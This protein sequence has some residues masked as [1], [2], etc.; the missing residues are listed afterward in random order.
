[1]EGPK[2]GW[3]SPLLG[4]RSFLTAATELHSLLYLLLLHLYHCSITHIVFVFSVHYLLILYLYHFY[5]P[6]CF[7]FLSRHSSIQT[8]VIGY[9][10]MY[11]QYT[12]PLFSVTQRHRSEEN[13]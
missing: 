11:V 9:I 8:P 5:M 3:Q 4:K 10:L 13:E 2:L 7:Y 6:Y 12:L 1:M